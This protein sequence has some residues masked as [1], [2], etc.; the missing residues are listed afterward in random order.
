MH[1]WSGCKCTKCG[2]TWAADLPE[3]LDT[4][5]SFSSVG[6]TRGK[7]LSAQSR[8]LDY[9]RRDRGFVELLISALDDKNCTV[10]RGAAIA[11]GEIGDVRGM[12]PLLS[13]INDQ[14]DC[15]AESVIES[16]GKI[17]DARAV[18]PILQQYIIRK[19]EK[20]IVLRA[21]EKIGKDAVDQLIECL[22]G[23][24]SPKFAEAR[25]CAAQALGLIG[26]PKAVGPLAH[27][28]AMDPHPAVR[29]IASDAKALILGELE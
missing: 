11:I 21:L 15:V 5:G 4:L 20:R 25:F 10:S 29:R 22:N 1:E 6:S 14:N 27:A 23:D 28:A 24:R 9:A 2:K 3:V 12:E 13:K 18:S 16:L 19:I 26:S 8:V 7:W 17:G